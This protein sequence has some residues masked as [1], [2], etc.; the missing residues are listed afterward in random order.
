MSF[1]L[2]LKNILNVQPRKRFQLS[3]KFV[4]NQQPIKTNSSIYSQ[5]ADLKQQDI[6]LYNLSSNLSASCSSRGVMFKFLLR[7][8]WLFSV[9]TP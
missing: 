1:S 4:V 3:P 6:Y 7:L 8:G 9:R 5:Y 2:T